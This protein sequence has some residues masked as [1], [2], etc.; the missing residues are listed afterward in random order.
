MSLKIAAWALSLTIL[1][2]PSQSQTICPIEL[3]TFTNPDCSETLPSPP[4]LI[5]INDNCHFVFDGLYSASCT[6]DVL[7]LQPCFDS[8]PLVTPKNYTLNTCFNNPNPHDNSKGSYSMFQ[9]SCVDATTCL[10]TNSPIASPSSPTLAPPTS[11]VDTTSKIA[12]T[13]ML[14]S[15]PLPPNS[16]ADQ[17]LDVN[18]AHEIVYLAGR[19]IYQ[20]LDE[21]MAKN[22]LPKQ[23]RFH[24]FEDTGST[25]VLIISSKL[26]ED[27]S[28]QKGKL[29]V[30]F[31]GT[32]D[33]PDGDWLRNINLPKVPYGPDNAILD[34]TVVAQDVFGSNRTY[35]VSSIQQSTLFAWRGQA[36]NCL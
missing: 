27:D 15:P 36:S 34:G 6:N 4:D 10:A 2:N 33:T 25:E 3:H 1:T 14:P 35:E 24:Y 7:Y 13:V 17:P 30:L 16:F 26:R 23:Y 5:S 19:L 8:S 20:M 29:M 28:D 22:L 31:R 9:G 21:E 11:D 32:D 18:L 12:D